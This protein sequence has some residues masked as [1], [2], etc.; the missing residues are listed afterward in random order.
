[1][2]NAADRAGWGTGFLRKFGPGLI[3]AAM[4]VGV[5]HLVQSTRAGAQY[6]LASGLLVIL[7]CAAKYP[8]FRFGI[9]YAATARE[10]LVEAYRR[11]GVGALIVLIIGAVSDMFIAT[12]AVTL[13]AAGL[14]KGALGLDTP[15]ATAVAVILVPLGSLI[16]AGGYGLFE[17][18]SKALVVLFTVLVFFTTALAAAKVG[19]RVSEI[20]PAVPITSTSILFFI[21]MTGWM[22]NPPSASFYISVWAAQ[23]AK[24]AGTDA[25]RRA[26]F[27]FNVG[28]W[29]TILVAL[30]FVFLGAV[31][32]YGADAPLTASAAGF[33]VQFLDVFTGAI[34]PWSFWLI[35]LAAAA[36]ILSTV[37]TLL[38]GCPRLLSGMVAGCTGAP[39][40]FA[41]LLVAQIAGA[42]AII[43]F[44]AQSFTRF[45][46]FA[47]SMSFVTAPMIAYFNHRAMMSL[48]PATG[49]RPSCAL[50]V[51][52]IA[53]MVVMGLA[54]AAFI[55]A[56][57][58]GAPVS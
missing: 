11:Q 47:A 8:V 22:P 39:A 28:Y 29:L 44:A 49:R 45:I 51:W 34:G 17:T 40:F 57:F 4:A 35:A 13:V 32:L 16:L 6:G 43:A 1:M 36:V 38:D 54:A 46:D 2:E 23:R 3:F 33:A 9:E 52:S 21:A 37:V 12:S 55:G 50:R 41:L 24:E 19:G 30:A 53:G 15:D 18:G 42:V 25:P 5:S 27:D 10:S 20:A 14:L 56:G 31:M 48:D 58:F 26:V 7:A